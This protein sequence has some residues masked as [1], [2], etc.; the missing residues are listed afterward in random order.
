MGKDDAKGGNMEKEDPAKA[1]W[2]SLCS[3]GNVIQPWSSP[4]GKDSEQW[5][6]GLERQPVGKSSDAVAVWGR[7]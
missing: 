7:Y 1:F 2:R 3:T 5:V 4:K 6:G